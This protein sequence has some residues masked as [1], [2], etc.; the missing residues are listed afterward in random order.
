MQ[1]QRKAVTAD[2]PVTFTFDVAGSQFL[3]KNFTSDIIAV[4]ILGSEVLI[5]ANSAQ[6]IAT[7]MEPTVK[8]LTNTL[9]V[10]AQVTDSTG[11]EIQCLSY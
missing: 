7:R 6:M 2:T 1:V 3:V 5:P 8:D 10:T 9:T 4:G 11:V